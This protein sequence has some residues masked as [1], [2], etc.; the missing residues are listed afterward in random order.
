MHGKVFLSSLKGFLTST[1]ALGLIAIGATAVIATPAHAQTDGTVAADDST[2]ED[3]IIVRGRRRDAELSIEA[4]RTAKQVIDVLSADQAS[5]LPDN[6]VAESLARIPGVS[7]TRSGETGNGNFISIRGLDSALANVQFN[8]VNSATA[9]GGNRRVPLDGISA[10]DIAEIRVSKSLLPQDEGEG[11]GGAVNIIANTPLRRGKDRVTFEA[12]GRYGEFADRLGYN[13]GGAFTKVFGETFG[14]NLSAS[15]RRR[16]LRNFEVD[17][18]SSNILSIPGITDASGAL[19]SPQ[20]ILNLGLDDAGSAFDNVTEGFLDPSD[21]TFEEQSYQLQD[22]IRDT[23]TITGAIDWRPVENTLLT[24]GGRMS[25]RDTA[26]TEASFGFDQDDQDFEVINNALVT[27]FT[28]AE[29]RAEFQ[30][31]DQFDLNANVFLKGE[32]DFE[33]LHLKY[34]ASYARATE[35]APQTD[36]LFDTNSLLSSGGDD[37]IPWSFVN[38]FFPVPNAS[39]FND[40][41]FIAGITDIA[42]T[43]EL[44]DF[45]TDL[46]NQTLDER[47]AA[48]FDATYDLEWE[49]FGGVFHTVSVGGKYERSDRREDKIE[50]VDNDDDLNLDGTF[51]E[52]AGTADG[53]STFLGDFPGLFTGGS[54]GLSPIN[55]PLAAAGVSSIPVLD[56]AAL[57]NLVSTFQDSF[58][59]QGG[60]PS[61]IDF[62]DSQEEVFSGYFQTEFEIGKLTLVGGVRVEHYDAVFATPLTLNADIFT[63]N[64]DLSPGSMPGDT[65]SNAIELD[66]TGVLQTINTSAD[67]TEILP[68]F[69]A[70][71]KVSDQFQ[72]RAGFGF[73]IARPTFSQLG[74]AS[75]IAIGLTSDSTEATFGGTAPILPGVSDAAAAIAAGGISLADLTDVTVNISSGN[76]DLENARSLNADLSFEY[77]PVRGTALTLGLF[78]KR[79]NNFIFVGQESD[80]GGST[81]IDLAAI[82][83]LLTSEGQTLV[84]GVGGLSGAL[85]SANADTINFNQPQNGDT[86]IV[87]GVELGITHQFTWAPGFLSD[88]GFFGNVTYTE[89]EA[90]YVVEPSLD[91][92]EALVALGFLQEDDP[93]L[94]ETNFFNAPNITAN[95]S[96]YYEAHGLEVALSAQ[97]Q[98]RAFDFTDDFGLDQFNGSF[99][100]MD[101]FVAYELPIDERYGSIKIF[102]EVPDVTDN[103]I[104]PTDLQQLGRTRVTFDEAS[105]NGREIRFGVRGRF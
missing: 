43:Q 48:K 6:N 40:P 74:N 104:K 69:N 57:R 25:R 65:I 4:K 87:Y 8:G 28:D 58:T 73:S 29:L 94:R 71:Y 105:F 53:G 17:S 27:Q 46:I 100:Q 51:S 85:G 47:Y 24:L 101:I 91:D 12:A 21:I 36:I 45:E 83:A 80:T 66:P 77:Y 34:Q 38:V 90:T 16:F 86:A 92:D 49:L 26:A 84:A 82:E 59:Q 97:Y 96:I 20:G 99:Y 70:L 62:F 64:A 11:I 54:V 14:V 7:V 78:Y 72:V 44:A 76:P 32:T 39:L 22:Q 50:L 88:V 79:I 1:S 55:N 75:T 81:S 9:N 41:D 56:E 98:G 61:E 15:Y 89:S 33:K 2:V 30:L 67:N 19:V 93:L 63:T 13:V 3:V 52:G 10:D 37:F 102:A 23:L 95:G 60:T 42:G 31:E 5:Q 18:S 103:G 68:R 35:R